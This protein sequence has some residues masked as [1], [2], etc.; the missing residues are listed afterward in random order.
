M[1]NW[2]NAGDSFRLSVDW[3]SQILYHLSSAATRTTFHLSPGSIEDT[4]EPDGV[5]VALLS[6]AIDQYFVVM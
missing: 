4:L 6:F 5:L 2:N 1:S 3:A